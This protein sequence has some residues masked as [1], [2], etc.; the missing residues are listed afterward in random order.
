MSLCLTYRHCRAAR[1]K[2]YRVD[3]AHQLGVFLDLFERLGVEVRSEHL[4]GDGCNLCALKGR[5]IMFIDLD[6][7]TATRLDSCASALAQL[8]Q[9]DKTFVPPEIR[10]RI[11]KIRSVGE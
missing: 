10:E 6:A 5:R 2:G 1:L 11:D 7:D 4:G 9:I 3:S 8:P